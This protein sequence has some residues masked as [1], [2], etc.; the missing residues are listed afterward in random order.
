VAAVGDAWKPAEVPLVKPTPKP[1]T[2][3]AAR[4][5]PVQ[6]ASIDTPSSRVK[7]IEDQAVDLHAEG[8]PSPNEPTADPSQRV[9]PRAVDPNAV[10]LGARWGA[11]DRISMPLGAAI[12]VSA[13]A[14][15]LT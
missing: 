11:Q 8:L 15:V 5:I 9:L 2:S 3:T 10:F 14:D 12:A 6:R 1:P 13:Q 4:P 7:L